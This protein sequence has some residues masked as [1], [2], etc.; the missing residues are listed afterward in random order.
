MGGIP[1]IKP[2]KVLAAAAARSSTMSTAARAFRRAGDTHIRFTVACANY[3]DG[4]AH[5]QTGKTPARRVDAGS[6]SLAGLRVLLRLLNALRPRT[7]GLCLHRRRARLQH[8][9]EDRTARRLLPRVRTANIP[10]PR[11]APAA[12]RTV[13]VAP[14]WADSMPAGTWH[15]W[16]LAVF[17]RKSSAE[18][19][20]SLF[21]W[22]DTGS[23]RH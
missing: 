8:R 4:Y 18:S 9:S 2:S 17:L 11:C 3:G 23:L 6:F 15:R 7:T 21:C 1:V 10:P 19:H 14:R 12:S 5:A 22:S 16:C 13:N 20:C